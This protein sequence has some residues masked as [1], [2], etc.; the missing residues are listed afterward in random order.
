MNETYYFDYLHRNKRQSNRMVPTNTTTLYSKNLIQIEGY[1]RPQF[2]E[3]VEK[4][5]EKSPKWLSQYVELVKENLKAIPSDMTNRVYKP[6]HK[7]NGIEIEFNCSKD[8]YKLTIKRNEASN[9]SALQLLEEASLATALNNHEIKKE[10]Q[11]KSSTPFYSGPINSDSVKEFPP[12]LQSHASQLAK[13][14]FPYTVKV[15]EDK[16]KV[17]GK[18]NFTGRKINLADFLKSDS[19]NT[20]TEPE[21][22]G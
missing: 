6:T 12:D 11:Q 13:S 21:S 20:E 16:I 5:L 17:G 14:D 18:V 7:V 10:R 4:I 8:S 22:D 19:S 9:K 2:C 15:G 3:K 1:S